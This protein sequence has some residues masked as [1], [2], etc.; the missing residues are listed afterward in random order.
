MRFSTLRRG[1]QGN[2]YVSSL[3]H[4]GH[5]GTSVQAGTLPRPR[6]LPCPSCERAELSPCHGTSA[7]RRA[8]RRKSLTKLLVELQRHRLI[9]S[10]TAKIGAHIWPQ[11]SYCLD[12]EKEGGVRGGNVF[13]GV[14][15]E[16]AWALFLA[17]PRSPQAPWSKSEKGAPSSALIPSSAG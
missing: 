14:M 17:R 7:V 16:T 11:E 4:A 5:V 8:W 12:R 9:S 2:I 6:A 15:E 3:V 1:D 13:H 10:P